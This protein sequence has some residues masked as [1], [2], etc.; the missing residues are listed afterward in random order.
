[1]VRE[2]PQLDSLP[3]FQQGLGEI[4]RDLGGQGRVLVRYSGTEPKLRLLAEGPSREVS[5]AT[6]KALGSLARNNLNTVDN[7]GPS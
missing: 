7:V 4:T 5:E 2:K 6:L 1:M 3:A